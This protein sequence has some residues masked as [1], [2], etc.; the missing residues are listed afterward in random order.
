[1]TGNPNDWTMILGGDG[2]YC[3]VDYTNANII[4]AE[5]QW[6]NLAKSTNGGVSFYPATSGISPSDRTNWSTPVIM[7]PN[8][9]LVLYYGANRLYKTTDGGT[10]WT[11]INNGLPDRWVTRVAVDPTNPAIAYVT[12]SGYRYDS[13]LPH[14]YRTTNYG[15]SW[16]DISSNLPS[17]TYFVQLVTPDKTQSRKLEIVK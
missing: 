14:V 6:G 2:F 10:N 3:I 4:Y 9:H 12:F 8:N 7:D 15:G 17:G 16:V 1:M 5:Y 13:P 11:P